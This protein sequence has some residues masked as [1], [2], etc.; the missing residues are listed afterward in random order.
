MEDAAAFVMESAPG[1]ETV[2][3]G[4]R[5]LYFGGTGY[6]GL[7]GHPEILAAGTAAFDRGTH[8]AT[9]RAGFGDTPVLLDLEAKLA[10]FFGAEA[11][12]YYPSGYLNTLILAQAL[13]GEFEAAFIDERAHF[14][15]RDGIRTTGKPLFEYRHRDAGDLR[16]RL[17]SGLKA[18]ERP[19]VLSDGVFPAFGELAPVPAL[20]EALAPYEGRLALDDAHGVGV[21]GP[22]G[23][24]TYEHFGVSGPRLHFTGTLS[25]AFGGYGGF[26]AAPAGL[27]A[28]VRRDVGAYAGS[29]PAPTPIA[30][31]SARGLELVRAHPEWRLRLRD[32]AARL[33]A[34]LR[35]LG[36]DPG[37]SP[38]P[39]AAWSLGSA[40][41]M[42][43]LQA[44]LLER[45]VALAYLHYAGT[46][47]G[48]VLRA[49]VFSTHTP[50]Q[51]DRLLDEIKRRV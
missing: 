33:K 47:S 50:A 30:A 17:K 29:S 44:A 25:K 40:D 45:G 51:I 18:G 11:A 41:E 4:R 48:G 2:I 21:L 42:K 5:C 43:R 3:N 36:I 27:V 10:A 37:D 12:A 8:S 26:L 19:L 34:G 16:A 6:F 28:Q 1:A 14:S 38:M 23:R 31:A 22:N 46:P 39:I 24:G 9:T 35:S 7:H 20:I 13:D 15:I 49:T 32:N